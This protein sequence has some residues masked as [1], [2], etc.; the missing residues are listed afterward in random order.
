MKTISNKKFKNEL[1]KTIVINFKTRREAL[2]YQHSLRNKLFNSLNVYSFNDYSYSRHSI[3]GAFHWSIRVK[4][5]KQ[6]THSC[7][8]LIT[9]TKRGPI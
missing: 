2:Q 8:V 7:E 1:H 5:V 3:D 9:K 4:S 6:K